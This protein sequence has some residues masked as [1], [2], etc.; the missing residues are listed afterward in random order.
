MLT[1]E[2]VS[3][4]PGAWQCSSAFLHSA[5]LSS[6]WFCLPHFTLQPCL[7]QQA[8]PPLFFLVATCLLGAWLPSLEQ[9][10]GLQHG[11]LELTWK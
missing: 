1:P 10:G 6:F 3:G 8:L 2:A 7:V 11:Q 5:P 4:E 9:D